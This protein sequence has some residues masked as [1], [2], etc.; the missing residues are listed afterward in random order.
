MAVKLTDI[1]KKAGVSVTTVSFV[2]NGKNRVSEEIKE[3]VFKIVKELDYCPNKT[4]QRLKGR[5]FNE[6][7]LII[8]GP[9]YEYFSNP[10]LFKIV[11][12][13]ALVLNAHNYTLTIKTTTSNKEEH[14]IKSEINSNLFDGFLLWGTRSPIEIFDTFFSYKTPIVSIARASDHSYSVAIDDFKGGFLITD[15]LLKKGYKNIAFL[16]KLNHISSA[17][18]RLEGYLKALKDKA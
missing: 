16:G 15:Y 11:Q 12:G 14:F 6:I 3:K 7:C 2:L 5:K 18:A 17:K 8:S 13:V 10:Y 1:A 9:N 4:A